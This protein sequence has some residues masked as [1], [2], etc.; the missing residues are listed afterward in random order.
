MNNQGTKFE[1]FP[2]QALAHDYMEDQIH[3][4]VG[5]GGGGRGGKTVFGA[6]YF[7]EMCLKYPDTRYGIGRKELKTLKSTTIVTLFR[8]MRRLGLKRGRHYIY[9]KIDGYIQF[10][11]ESMILLMDLKLYPQDPL[12]ENL[13]G[14]ELTQ[15]WVDEAGEVSEMAIN[16]LQTRVGN[17]NNSKYGIKGKVLETFNPSKGHLYT[18]YW[19]RSEWKD[20]DMPKHRV[21]IRALP[22]DNPKIEPDWIQRIL[23]SGN[24]VL[25]QRLIYGNFDYDDNKLKIFN[26]A[27]IQDLF[28]NKFVPVGDKR[29]MI[30]DPAGKGK[31]TTVIHIWA[32]WRLIY[33]YEEAFTKQDLL[34]DK[35]RELQEEYSVPNSQTIADYSGIGVG[36]VDFLGCKGFQGGGSAIST[37]SQK[38]NEIE[39]T[40]VY[41]NL[42]S[43]CFFEIAK[44]V[45][46]A[47]IYIEPEAVGEAGRSRIIN[48]LDVIEEIAQNDINSPKAI[49]P[50]DSDKEGVRTIKKL[51][52]NSPD[53]ADTFSMRYYFELDDSS[54]EFTVIGW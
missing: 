13:G 15:A 7:I 18:R 30:I 46:S 23:D 53:D 11:N 34:Y 26:Y 6:G 1:Y 38:E 4:E 45:N 37:E 5:Y 2:K 52:G 47:E 21:F 27:K 9:N 10:W 16:V 19:K 29:Y 24:E 14:L 43:Q 33:R 31:D 39:A 22:H 42:R 44:K 12:F 40:K 51:L 20:N 28:T 17:W 35:I 41:R 8:E 36:L 50:K 3:T 25:I 54:D 32:G 49:I 48:E